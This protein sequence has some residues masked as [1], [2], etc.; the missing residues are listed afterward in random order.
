[1]KLSEDAIPVRIQAELEIGGERSPVVVRRLGSEGLSA[2]LAS[3]V[4]ARLSP[5]QEVELICPMPKEA[6]P[7]RWMG[8]VAEVGRDETADG[9]PVEFRLDEDGLAVDSPTGSEP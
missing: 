8:Q 3:A 1:M 5:G 9:V 7:V 6:N 2:E 4:A